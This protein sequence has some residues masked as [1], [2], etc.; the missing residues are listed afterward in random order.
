MNARFLIGAALFAISAPV[1]AQDV[2]ITNAT[3][4]IGD[5][6]EPVT[7]A[8]VVIRA[9]RVVAAGPGVAVPAGI[10]AIDGT[11]KW[12]TPGL[13]AAMTALGLSDAD[14]VEESNDRSARTSPFSAA[15]DV[16]P[17]LNPAS[18]HVQ[19]ARGGGITGTAS[20]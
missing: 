17:A 11:G 4:A 3:V 2:A 5:G 8:T 10:E 12:V 19:V 14:G 15:L 18:Q 16:A 1:F 6:S 13:F 20:C 9:G 7:G